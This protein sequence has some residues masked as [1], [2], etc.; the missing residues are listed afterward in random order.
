MTG[1]YPSCNSATCGKGLSIWSCRKY[2]RS[3]EEVQALTEE[4]KVLQDREDIEIP[5]EVK[6]LQG[7]LNTLLEQ[8][9]HRWKQRA[10]QLW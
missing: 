4:L 7:K 10:I 6:S 8:E 9:N 5:G 1:W 3:S 2:R